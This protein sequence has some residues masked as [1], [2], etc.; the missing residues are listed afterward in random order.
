M[1]LEKYSSIGKKLKFFSIF[2]VV[3]QEF[4]SKNKTVSTFLNILFETVEVV[5]FENFMK[6]KSYGKN[7]SVQKY[8]FKKC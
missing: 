5:G 6:L 8:D 7:L 4:L 1:G 3:P 2:D